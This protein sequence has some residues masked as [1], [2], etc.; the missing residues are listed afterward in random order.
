M[1]ANTTTQVLH[2]LAPLVALA[3]M[4]ASHA[5]LCRLRPDAAILNLL[6][7]AG[8]AGLGGLF[9][10]QLL[11]RFA[12]QPLGGAFVTMMLVDGPIYACLAYGYA[13]FVNL[14]H[15]SVR[16]RIY[17]ELLD[18]PDGIPISELQGRYDEAGM[19]SA[20]LRRMLDAEDLA[21]DGVAYRLKKTRLLAISKVVFGLKKAVL[22]RQSEFTP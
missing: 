14:G 5:V 10:T 17:R 4:A 21:F 9:A 7:V 22:G 1:S 15:A 11:A 2:L 3:A 12:G 20:R 6:V 16:I 18:S 19:L 8:F 13:N